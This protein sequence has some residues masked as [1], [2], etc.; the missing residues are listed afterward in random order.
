MAVFGKKEEMKSV[1]ELPKP[2]SFN[3]STAGTQSSLGTGVS[4]TNSSLDS[5]SP[6]SA[7]SPSPSLP[8][9]P[10][11]SPPSFTPPTHE[12]SPHL[13]GSQELLT[14]DIE[15]IAESIID[16]KWEKV[17]GELDDLKTWKVDLDTQVKGFKSQLDTLG[18]RVDDA[19]N[20]MLGKVEEY[21]KSLG[22]VN[23][24]IQ[25]MGKVFEKII[26]QFTENVNKLSELVDRKASKT[27]K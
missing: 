25:A 5:P 11:P 24:E 19:Q 13:S 23:V 14:E 6:L 16:E 17:K 8:T 22:G 2:A 1:P 18:K 4:P 10:L 9:P 12:S 21:N 15:K 26:P 27:K 3:P 20:A 7:P